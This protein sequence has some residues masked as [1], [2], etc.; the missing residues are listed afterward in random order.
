MKYLIAGH[1]ISLLIGLSLL[2][3]V[4]GGNRKK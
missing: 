3:I 4:I 2:V 1:I